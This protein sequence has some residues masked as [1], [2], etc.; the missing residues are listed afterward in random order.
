M[1][2][3]DLSGG[4]TKARTKPNLLGA[5]QGALADAER[6]GTLAFTG[7]IVTSPALA[8]PFGGMYS[9]RVCC[10]SN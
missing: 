5:Y 10:Q 7:V 2:A 8:F 4:G 6:R 3:F 1:Q 9:V